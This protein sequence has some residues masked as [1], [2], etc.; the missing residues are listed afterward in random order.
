MYPILNSET[1]WAYE[2][3]GLIPLIKKII[4]RYGSQ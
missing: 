2:F 1:E 3:N 4:K